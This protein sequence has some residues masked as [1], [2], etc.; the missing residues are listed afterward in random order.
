GIRHHPPSAESS[1]SST[2]ASDR[3]DESTGC[4]AGSDGQGREPS[5]LAD[6][7]SIHCCGCYI[8]IAADDVDVKVVAICVVTVCDNQ[9]RTA[10]VAFING[11]LGGR[12][13]GCVEQSDVLNYRGVPRQIL[14]GAARNEPITELVRLCA[15][16]EKC[17][18]RSVVLM[19]LYLAGRRIIP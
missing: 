16:H 12:L 6:N 18:G 1:A 19:E 9:M 4:A 14:S 15:S 10:D 17:E 11:E 8:G 3:C 2:Y 5:Y 13:V 7:R